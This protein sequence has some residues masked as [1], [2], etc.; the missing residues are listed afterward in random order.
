MADLR[1]CMSLKY[2]KKR[3]HFA[4]SI[5]PI[6]NLQKTEHFRIKYTPIHDWAV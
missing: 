4:A 2:Q 5:K 3:K 1:I 6:S